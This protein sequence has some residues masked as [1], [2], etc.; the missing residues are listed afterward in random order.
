MHIDE[1][2][3]QAFSS[4]ELYLMWLFQADIWRG[5]TVLSCSAGQ[6]LFCFFTFFLLLGLWIPLSHGDC[7]QGCL[8]LSCLQKFFLVY[9]LNIRSSRAAFLFALCLP[10][11][12]SCHHIVRS[13]CTALPADVRVVKVPCESQALYTRCFLQLF[14]KDHIYF[15]FL[16]KEVYIR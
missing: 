7:S 6:F 4:P 5:L 9:S 11:S 14:G 16:V 2:P 13:W 8:W 10:V 3:P 15:F 12:G 1:I